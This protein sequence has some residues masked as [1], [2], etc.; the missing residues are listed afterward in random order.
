MI[1]RFLEELK[2][3]NK[4]TNF[5][6]DHYINESSDYESVEDLL[7]NMEDLQQYGCISGM[8][9]ELIYYDDTNDFF[10][11][12][13]E[14]INQML[15]ETIEGTGCSIEELF[16]NKFDKEDP[17]IIECINKNLF[18]W[19]GFEETAYHLYDEVCEKVKNNNLAI[20]V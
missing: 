18:A 17:L 19:F 14:E 4:L 3:K 2:G 5:V 9:P 8:I 12:Y 20:E 15:F 7:S 11:N 1:Q 10:D 6:I 13:K 16:G